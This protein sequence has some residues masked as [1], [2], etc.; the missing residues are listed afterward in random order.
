MLLKISGLVVGYTTPIIGPLSFTL[1]A[2]Q[3]LGIVGANGCGKSTLLKSFYGQARIFSGSV[4]RAP[5]ISLASQQ[6]H[7]VRLTD[8]PVSVLDYLR[9]LGAE[10]QALPDR[11]AALMHKRI[12]TLSGGQYQLLA[13]WACL[14]S[15]ARV[16]LLDEPTNNLDPE[17]VTLLA[18]WLRERRDDRGLLLISHDADFMS[19]VCDASINVTDQHHSDLDP[20]GDAT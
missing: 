15:S 9:L 17:G 14:A 7:P 12:D 5:G 13:V 2:G 19:A 11:L 10:K 18:S 4:E 20:S 1:C 16:V 3:A 8:T 6:Q